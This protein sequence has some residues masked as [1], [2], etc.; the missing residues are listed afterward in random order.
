M[1]QRPGTVILHRGPFKLVNAPEDQPPESRMGD[2]D[3][4]ADLSFRKRKAEPHRGTP[5]GTR[6]SS[7]RASPPTPTSGGGSPPVA[8][9][10][11]GR[12]VAWTAPTSGGVGVGVDIR[13]GSA[14]AAPLICPNIKP[15]PSDT[16]RDTVDQS[17]KEQLTSV[18][19]LLLGSDVV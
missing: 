9:G 8:A 7:A 13:G 18:A 15:P 12:P 10:E 2:P 6:V 17:P 19:R 3:G 1:L 11:S 14:T 4:E 16:T 5:L